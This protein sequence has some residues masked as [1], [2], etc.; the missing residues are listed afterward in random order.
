M[1]T[2]LLQLINN[3]RINRGSGRLVFN[4]RLNDMAQ[5][6]A[7]DME[8]NNYFDHTDSQGRSFRERLL[9]YGF[10]S[11]AE[12]IA[13]GSDPTTVF[14][15]WRNSPPHNLNMLSKENTIAGIGNSGRYWVLVLSNTRNIDGRESPTNTPINTNYF[16]T[17]FIIVSL[18][19]I[20]SVVVY[21]ITK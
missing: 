10:M 21:T 6:L 7:Q 18:L 5:F 11:G 20:L 1:S 2:S 8:T 15:L 4:D 19:I 14:E 13:T 17:I 3:Y 9:S 12:N 16:M